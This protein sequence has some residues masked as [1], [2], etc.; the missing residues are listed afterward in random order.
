MCIYKDC[1]QGTQKY[2]E[3]KEHRSRRVK[4]VSEYAYHP[5]VPRKSEEPR[6][7]A[8]AVPDVLKGILL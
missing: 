3:C 4:N 8:L 6:L 7:T 1:S 2:R 5:P